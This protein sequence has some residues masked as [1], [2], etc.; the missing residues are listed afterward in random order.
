MYIQLEWVPIY[1]L[2]GFTAKVLFLSALSDRL[3][4]G[5]AGNEEGRTTTNC[6]LLIPQDE[7]SISRYHRYFYHHHPYLGP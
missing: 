6:S 7:S 5:F 2:E 4:D 1:H 3:V